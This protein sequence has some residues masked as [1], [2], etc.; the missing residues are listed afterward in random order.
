MTNK[1]ETVYRPVLSIQHNPAAMGI[2]E[3]FKGLV[4]NYPM[5]F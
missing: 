5:D 3:S 1:V 4:L 2:Y